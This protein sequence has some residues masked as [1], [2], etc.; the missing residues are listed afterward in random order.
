MQQSERRQRE[1]REATLSNHVAYSEMDEKT[2]Q[3]C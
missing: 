2:R 3:V 1:K